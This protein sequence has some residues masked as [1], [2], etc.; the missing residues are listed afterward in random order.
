MKRSRLSSAER[1]VSCHRSST[2]TPHERAINRQSFDTLHAGHGVDNLRMSVPGYLRLVRRRML[3]LSLFAMLS[4]LFAGCTSPDIY[5]WGRYEDLLYTSYSKP[6]KAPAEMQ[7][8]RMEADYKKACARNQRVPPGFHA[9][10]G[11]LYSQLGRLDDA[12]KQFETEKTEFPESA[13]FVDQLIAR[14]NKH[15]TAAK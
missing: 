13:L 11:H 7:L 12:R 15:E 10:L 9:H 5:S 14:L 2:L 1:R 8:E 4:V 6:E 3:P